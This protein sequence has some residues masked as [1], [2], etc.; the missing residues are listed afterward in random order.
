MHSIAQHLGKFEAN[1]SLLL[2][3]TVYAKTGEGWGE[4]IGDCETFGYFHYVAGKRYGFILSED[5][6]GFVYVDTYP[7]EEALTKWRALEKEY[8]TY[9]DNEG[10]DN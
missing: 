4:S 7:K 10:I 6:Q 9:C 2:A 3:E 5:S 8:E 1:P